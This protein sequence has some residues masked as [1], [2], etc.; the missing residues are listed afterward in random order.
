MIRNLFLPLACLTVAAA[1]APKLE[2]RKDGTALEIR[3]SAPKGAGQVELRLYSS[4]NAAI[5]KFTDNSPLDPQP[6]DWQDMK[7][8]TWYPVV[9]VELQPEMAG[10]A[11]FDPAPPAAVAINGMFY[12]EKLPLRA[13]MEF[14]AN[15]LELWE[16]PIW[17]DSRDPVLRSFYLRRP[18]SPGELRH[19]VRLA[20]Q[21][22]SGR[23]TL[24]SVQAGGGREL[25]AV[26]IAAP[27]RP[28]GPPRPG[29]LD[30]KNLADSL[31]ATVRFTLRS[32]N[33]NAKSPLDG[34][35]HLF[36]DLDAK[37]HRSSHWIW[38]WGPSVRMLLDAEKI[39][40]VAARFEKGQLLKAAGAIGR[41][42]LR[43]QLNQK[44]HPADAVPTSRWE[45]NPRFEYGHREALTASDG[46][47][48][49]GWAWIPLYE[50]TKDER[51]LEAAK[52]LAIS[53]GRISQMF[54]IVPQNYWTDDGTWSDN[55]MDES[56][57]G[58][59][60]FAELFRV[61]GDPTYREI[62]RRYIEQHLATLQ[63]DDG[64]WNR[65]W[66]RSKKWAEPTPFHTR[67]QGWAMEGLLASHRM[68]P[69]GKYRAL[70]VRMAERLLAAQQP[71]GYWTFYFTQPKEKVGIGGKST[72]LW[73]M[74]MY[75]LY[76][77]TGD[78]RHLRSARAALSWLIAIQY[79]GP[80]V[81]AEGGIVEVNP[82]SAVGY[83]PWYRV[84]CTYGSA[85]FGL[86]VL[87]ELEIQG[88][89]PGG[90]LHTSGGR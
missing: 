47:F 6:R 21:E 56:G 59:E 3:A 80:D 13:R 75:R 35:L 61:T 82:H 42:S 46:N 68:I 62:G 73:S 63:R 40:E 69:D 39:P 54:E 70:A 64:L 74:L 5:S 11:I 50:A 43:F 86:A 2:V 12:R 19:T 65:N 78:E 51:Y 23:V 29:K 66:Y 24:H 20:S 17:V 25:A 41:A 30:R 90:R 84:A 77:L 71:E 67:G 26:A 38:G 34:G 1:P 32:Q 83:R 9:D 85:F 57:F 76:R 15:R 72:A 87:E 48:L 79:T 53:T 36:Y 18:V 8:E 58:T 37:V 22:W 31:A 16:N 7:R 14:P 4:R 49:S 10:V 44:G 33:W 60:G 81:Q 55:T 89:G 27:S 28:A 52:R 88:A 45:R